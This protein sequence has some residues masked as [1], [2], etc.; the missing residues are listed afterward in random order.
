M[1]AANALRLMVYA[2]QRAITYQATP[3]AAQA[4]TTSAGGVIDPGA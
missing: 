1:D 4:P 2:G 3:A